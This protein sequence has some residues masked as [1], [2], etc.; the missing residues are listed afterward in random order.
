LKK[1]IIDDRNIEKIEIDE[2][3]IKMIKKQK[4]IKNM[5]I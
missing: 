1:V 4:K 2:E 3:F 5:K